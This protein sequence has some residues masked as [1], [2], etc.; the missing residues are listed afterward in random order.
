MVWGCSGRERGCLGSEDR[1]GV[2]R[3]R[4]GY[5]QYRLVGLGFRVGEGCGGRHDGVTRRGGRHRDGG[6]R[7]GRGVVQGHVDPCGP[8]VGLKQRLQLGYDGLLGKV[9][10]NV[11][12]L[13]S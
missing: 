11:D 10:H 8:A 1:G 12:D 13:G 6:E 3:C 4:R 9:T 5:L 2:L 7:R